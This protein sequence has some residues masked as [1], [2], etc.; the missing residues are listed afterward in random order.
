MTERCPKCRGDRC[1]HCFQTGKRLYEIGEQVV[2]DNQE[3]SLA[4]WNVREED[5][6]R[7]VGK[8]YRV[9]ALMAHP[10]D[11]E[12]R[13]YVGIDVAMETVDGRITSML[14][15][16]TNLRRPGARP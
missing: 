12:N 10:G 14:V 16:D 3:G 6:R 11:T 1:P 9:N 5:Y 7:Y 13:Y 15:F 8:T 4:P 2:W